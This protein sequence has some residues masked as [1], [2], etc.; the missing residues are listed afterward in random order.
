METHRRRNRRRWGWP[1]VATAL[2]VATICAAPRAAN[3]DGSWEGY[4]DIPGMKLEFSV[5]FETDDSGEYVGS[6]DI[7]AQNA[8]DLPVAQIRVNEDSVLFAL[9][10]I[11][12][13]PE[14]YGVQS[15]DGKS[16][17]GNF[18]QGGQTFP[19]TMT[20]LDAATEAARDEALISKLDSICAF[21]DSMRAAWEVPGAAVAII[22]DGEVILSEGFGLRNVADSLPVTERTL[23]A[24]GSSTKAFTT[25]VLGLLAEEGTISW[26]STVRGYLPTFKLHDPFITEHMTVRDLV[27]HRSGLPR[28]DMMWYGASLSRKELFDRLQHLEFSEAFRTAFQYQNLMFMTAGYLAGT[29]AG[30]TWEELVQQRILDPLGMTN[31]NFSVDLSQQ[32]DD[33]ALAY[34]EENDT[35][36][37]MDFRNIDAMGP[38]GSINSDLVDMAKWVRVQLGAP[39]GEGEPLVSRATLNEMHSPVTP[40]DRAGGRYHERLL[41][42]Y[43]LGWFIEAYRGHFRVFHGGNIDGFSALVSLLPNDGLGMVV[44]VNKNATPLPGIVSLYATDVLLDMDPVD[45]SGRA[46]QMLDRTDST[47]AGEEQTPADRVKDTKPSHELEAYVAE[48]EH[49]AYGIL[50]ITREGKKLY[51][52]LHGLKSEMEHW[53]YDVFRVTEEPLGGERQFITFRMNAGGYIHEAEMLLEA[54]VPEARFVRKPDSRLADPTF[55]ARFTGEYEMEDMV[56]TVALRGNRLVVT[57]PG[58]PTYTLKPYR[59]SEFTLEGLTGFSVEF[60]LESGGPATAVSFKQPNGIFKAERVTEEQ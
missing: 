43:G 20:R 30:A 17:A 11:P 42:S 52:E 8:F 13:N 40:I 44:L 53:H 55:L 16:I 50:E 28:H 54:T 35:L 7:P 38:A 48:Y 4:I 15:E 51:A 33:Y 9:A 12:G 23:F 58:Q 1:L 22:K 27:T 32:S 26:D 5:L 49:P 60:E 34:G 31:T 21:V 59:G 45:F 25:T 37:R 3:L 6:V 2:I 41:T 14:F 29:V 24:I 18:I 39:I 57:V 19:F 56:I 47:R 46:Q 36:T 10:V